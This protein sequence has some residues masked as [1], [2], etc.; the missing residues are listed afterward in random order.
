MKR[1]LKALVSFVSDKRWAEVR[2]FLT[3]VGLVA[4]A[5]IA[6]GTWVLIVWY[7]DQFAAIRFRLANDG[8]EATQFSE[9]A[10]AGLT[11][12]PSAARLRANRCREQL[13]QFLEAEEL[14]AARPAALCAEAG[15]LEAKSNGDDLAAFGLFDLYLDTRTT[16]FFS[17]QGDRK[18][19]DRLAEENWCYFVE[20]EVAYELGMNEMFDDIICY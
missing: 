9:V 20:T 4:G 5:L 7:P 2:N 12:G 10:N 11:S 17:H 14:V 6:V 8:I 16:N 1:F 18:D 3:V 15:Y 19:L 13:L